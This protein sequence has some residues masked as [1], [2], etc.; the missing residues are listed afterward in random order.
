[1][2]TTI[3][4]PLGLPCSKQVA[5]DGFSARQSLEPVP[6]MH[7]H[8][9]LFFGVA[10]VGCHAGIGQIVLARGHQD[11]IGGTVESAKAEV[12]MQ[13]AGVV[14]GEA[15]VWQIRFKPLTTS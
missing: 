4:S 9:S 14:D 13:V 12:I 1:M 10:G 5:V 6:E 11:C 2:L 15:E 8:A 7:H 3:P